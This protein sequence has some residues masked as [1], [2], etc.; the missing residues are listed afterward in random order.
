MRRGVDKSRKP[1]NVRLFCAMAMLCGKREDIQVVHISQQLA[2]AVEVILSPNSSQD[3]RMQATRDCEEFK[4]NKSY[5]TNCGIYLYSNHANFM[6]KHFGLQ[7]MHHAVKFNW[8]EMPEEEKN[9]LKLLSL[10]L[11]EGCTSSLLDEPSY[12][13]DAIAKFTVEIMKRE[14]PQNWP[15]VIKTLSEISQKGP[16]Q[17]FTVLRTL[18][19]LAEE[20]TKMDGDL[21]GP[22]RKDMM[23]SIN[24]ILAD[25]FKFFVKTLQLTAEKMKEMKT[26]YGNITQKHTE[27]KHTEV[28][29]QKTL[30]E[31][32][33]VTL[34]GFVE[35]VN[36]KYLVQEEAILLQTLCLLLQ[37]DELRMRAAECLE[38]IAG[39]KGPLLERPPLLIL[40]STDALTLI[41]SS[42]RSLVESN[43]GNSDDENHSF[44]NRV[45]SILSLMG[46]TQLAKLW[47]APGCEAVDEPAHF[48]LY[49]EALLSLY[50]H[51]N[52]LTSET[53]TK[54]WTSF[55]KNKAISTNPTFCSFIPQIL[56]ISKTKISRGLQPAINSSKILYP[57]TDFGSMAEKYNAWTSLRR[58]TKDIVQIITS[59]YPADAFNHAASWLLKLTNTPSSTVTETSAAYYEWDSLTCF[60]QS[61]ISK[62]FNN[63]AE[64]LQELIR[65]QIRMDNTTI[66][67]YDLAKKC[68]ENLVDYETEALL[69][70]SSIITCLEP[71]IP[72]LQYDFELLIKVI[73]KIFH[74]ASYQH[75]N[76][77]DNILDDLTKHIQMSY[78]NDSCTSLER[79]LLAEG[80]VVISNGYVNFEKQEKYIN[81][82]LAPIRED[83]MSPEL[84]Q[85]LSS[86]EAF[87]SFIGLYN[88]NEDEHI[89][90]KRRYTL[91]MCQRYIH[92]V[93]KRIE[94]PKDS[95]AQINGGFKTRHEDVPR[96]PGTSSVLPLLS[97]IFHL[98]RVFSRIWDP[99]VRV[100]IPHHLQPA[101]DI[102]ESEKA[103]IF[104]LDARDGEER[105]KAEPKRS[106]V[107]NM[108]TFLFKL[109]EACAMTLA[110]CSRLGEGF[111]G[112]PSLGQHIVTYVIEPWR[113]VPNYRLRIFIRGF[114]KMY[115]R[116]CPPSYYE[117]A[118]VPVVVAA[119]SLMIDHLNKDWEVVRSREI[120]RPHLAYIE[121]PDI[122]D[123]EEADKDSEIIENQL[124]HLLTKNFMEAFFSMCTMK[125][126]THFE[127]NSPLTTEEPGQV[128]LK[129]DCSEDMLEE[130]PQFLLR[131]P[132]TCKIFL[133]LP[134]V[135]LQWPDTAGFVKAAKLCVPFVK[136]IVKNP[137][138][139]VAMSQEMFDQIF[140]L[141]LKGLQ[142]MGH[143]VEIGAQLI[144]N[145]VTI[146]DIL[147]P[148][149]PSLKDILLQVPNVDPAVVNNY[150]LTLLSENSHT[151]K[152]KRKIFR[153]LLSGL[154]GKEIGKLFQNDI[155]IL[156][157][158]ALPVINKETPSTL[159]DI[160]NPDYG[161]TRLFEPTKP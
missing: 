58:S 138:T 161:L 80:L 43:D 84:E 28:V 137:P 32:V 25:L 20:S 122:D 83:W 18:L 119:L 89:T 112:A 30:A 7:L 56:E 134:F 98:N 26:Q 103:A 40:F 66:G 107:D 70:K 53:I 118:V 13:K 159:A 14:W 47:G 127:S 108:K 71:F 150:D 94:I 6:V 110:D 52:M 121:A 129:P 115:C 11:T 22:R 93:L 19:F 87:L 155:T 139:G 99:A 27:T 74:S 86:P 152:Q 143:H 57:D 125:R 102:H 64:Y 46:E 130:L 29:I 50:R 117:S 85:A 142:L 72:F 3:K 54:T 101:L 146:Y 114:F 45:C 148:L 126:P 144:R 61:V 153:G 10:N 147:R 136:Q 37:E 157:L 21:P 5:L 140:T 17:L 63:D 9:D 116:V 12:I 78:D 160:E 92:A 111:Y 39:R 4:N 31:S 68:I 88:S 82:L 34:C 104:G 73:H 123:E 124:V 95:Q 55:L 35:W 90:Q 120:V 141:C 100:K 91:N 1:A 151:E 2:E 33:L 59:L 79:S 81:E 149:F 24:I 51:E 69:I 38:S 36:V 135:S 23:S 44:L 145:A 48:H 97:N 49:L 96:N 15:D 60:A 62:L 8:N 42:I 105:P 154:I 131:H 65:C 106:P 67:F 76:E 158:P 41:F 77:E 16:S 109:N 132:K 75:P 156:N 113:Y 128:L 133:F